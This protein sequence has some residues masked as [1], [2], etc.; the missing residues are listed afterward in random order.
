MSPFE[1]CLSCLLKVTEADEPDALDIVNRC[2]ETYL[3]SPDGPQGIAHPCDDLAEAVM[4][5]APDTELRTR[6]LDR[7]FQV[8]PRSAR[9]TPSDAVQG[10]GATVR[11]S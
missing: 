4:A 3:A 9:T 6:V 5:K 1:Q 10:A 11:S 7:L 8:E 2:I